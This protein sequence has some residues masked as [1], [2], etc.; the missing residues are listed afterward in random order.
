MISRFLYKNTVAI[1][2][3]FNIIPYETID[4]IPM[5]NKNKKKIIAEGLSF[6]ISEKFKKIPIKEQYET[7][8]FIN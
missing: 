5:I 3:R 8:D 6:K 7:K 4:F 1:Q 2:R